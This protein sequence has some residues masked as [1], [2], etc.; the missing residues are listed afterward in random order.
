MGVG[1]QIVSSLGAYLKAQAQNA[2][3][4]VLLY[5]AGFAI[6]GVPWWFLTGWVCGGIN[7]IPYL[8]PV[9]ALALALLFKAIVLKSWIELLYVFGLWLLIQIAD[10]FVLSPRAAGRAGVHPLVAI[11]LTIGAGILFGP[12]G[13]VLAVPVMAVVL[14]ITKAARSGGPGGR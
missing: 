13:I 6:L 9:I 10:G 14:V 12:L 7:L 5:I 8:G 3:V 1:S 11:P 2:L 4:I